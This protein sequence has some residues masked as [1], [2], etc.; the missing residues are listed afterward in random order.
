MKTVQKSK[1]MSNKAIKVV[2]AIILLAGL[3]SGGYFAYARV[4]SQNATSTTDETPLQ[5]AKATRGDLVLYADGTGIVMPAAESSLGFNASGQ[6]SEIYVEIGDQ[7]EA[8]QVLAQ[9]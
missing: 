1:L 2:A 7:V 6:V 8:G 4:A 9:L 5:T 3:I